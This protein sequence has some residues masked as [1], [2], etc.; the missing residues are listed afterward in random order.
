M[1][2]QAPMSARVSRERRLGAGRTVE[3]AHRRRRQRAD[4]VG[5]GAAG[6]RPLARAGEIL[7]LDEGEAEV[8]RHG[9]RSECCQQAQPGRAAA[10]A[11]DVKDVCRTNRGAAA[12]GGAGLAPLGAASLLAARA[13]C[14]LPGREAEWWQ[15]GHGARQGPWMSWRCRTAPA[16]PLMLR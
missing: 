16:A 2:G 13:T 1:C 10:D 4:A 5:E 12:R 15:R 7:A 3:E 8:R 14:R 9:R 6:R 11:D